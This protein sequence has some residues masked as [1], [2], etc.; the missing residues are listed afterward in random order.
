VVLQCKFKSKGFAKSN[1]LRQFDI[2]KD[3]YIIIFFLM[4][5]IN[6]KRKETTKENIEYKLV[7]H[8]F[9]KKMIHI[10]DYEKITIH[11]I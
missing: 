10:L 2:K 3:K 7:N 8:C 11:L 5:Q 9:L 6:I 1:A 4:F